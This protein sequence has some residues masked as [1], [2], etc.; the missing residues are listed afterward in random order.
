MRYILTIGN[1]TDRKGHRRDCSQL[2]LRW[3]FEA[4]DDA[5]AL[6]HCQRLR[7]IPLDGAGHVKVNGASIRAADI[8]RAK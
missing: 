8:R 5:D 1:T 4:S 2:A 3:P 6:A 7:R